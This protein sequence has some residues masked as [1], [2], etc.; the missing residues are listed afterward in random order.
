MRHTSLTGLTVAV[1]ILSASTAHAQSGYYNRV[2]VAKRGASAARLP[3]QAQQDMFSPYR[4]STTGYSA[5]GQYS[6]AE[7]MRPPVQ[8]PRPSAAQPSRR[9]YY[10]GLPT[11]Q[12]ANRN[13]ISPSRLCVPGRRAFIY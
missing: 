6:R 9:N 12:G 2:T 3:A 8:P 4:G 1:L 7:V 5:N 13:Y 10:P 11:G